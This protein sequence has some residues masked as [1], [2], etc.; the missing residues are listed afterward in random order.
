MLEYIFCQEA[1]GNTCSNDFGSWITQ[2]AQ[3]MIMNS[4]K[5]L[6]KCEFA[7]FKHQ[8]YV[9]HKRIWHE[10]ENETIY[11]I[12]VRI[13]PQCPGQM[14][15]SRCEVLPSLISELHLKCTQRGK[16]IFEWPH[17]KNLTA[18]LRYKL[19]SRQLSSAWKK[20]HITLQKG[21]TH[22]H[23]LWISLPSGS[24]KHFVCL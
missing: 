15:S 6:P 4:L 16:C 20:P 19:N 1:S 2:G 24:D 13:T 17:M 11:E 14:P 22:L 21:I 12:G 7:L 23:G 3:E 5:Y 9:L 10:L 8:I 18:D